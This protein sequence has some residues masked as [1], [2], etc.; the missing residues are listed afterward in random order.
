[1]QTP[2][3]TFLLGLGSTM[4]LRPAVQAQISGN[5]RKAAKEANAHI[6]KDQLPNDLPQAKILY[7][8]FEPVQVP[9]Q[10]PEGMTSE[11]YTR[12][13]WHNQNC[14]WSG[15]QLRQAARK[16][17]FA[18][19][20]TT[21]DSVAYY[22]SQGY[23]YLLFH[24]SF[25]SFLTNNYQGVRTHMSFSG[26]TRYFQEEITT[27]DLYV[28]DLTTNDFYVVDKFSEHHLYKY[29]L[30][31]PLLTKKASKTFPAKS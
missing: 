8:K 26:G 1:M 2:T 12:L 5:Y 16:Y 22:R 13:R 15:D 20:I 11:A 27:V 19:R 30:I 17:P 21:Q 25:N 7:I 18:Y 9:A 6:F 24:D 3:L 31:I 14:G 28:Q 29:S 4:F 10:R 23:K